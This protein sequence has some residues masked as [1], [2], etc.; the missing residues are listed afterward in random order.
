[1]ERIEDPQ[2]SQRRIY[3]SASPPAVVIVYLMCLEVSPWDVLIHSDQ[4]AVF[5]LPIVPTQIATLHKWARSS[6]ARTTHVKSMA[7]SQ[8]HNEPTILLMSSMEFR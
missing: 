1:M 8:P 4:S 7:T 3:A 2:T 6:S 5:H